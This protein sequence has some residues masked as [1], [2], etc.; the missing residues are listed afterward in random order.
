MAVEFWP[1]EKVTPAEY[2]P[3]RINDAKI[4]VLKE[5][6][7]K[8]GFIIP[9]LVNTK[10]NTIIAGHQRTKTANLLGLKTIPVNPVKDIRLGDEVRFNQIHNSIDLT[11]DNRPRL[12]SD[13]YDKEQFVYIPPEKFQ[14]KTARASSLKETCE[15]I[16]RYGNCLSCIVCKNEVVYGAEYVKAC[17]LLKLPVT[18]Y[19]ADDSKYQD[20]RYYLRQDYG[21]FCY[22]DIER[23][24]YVQGLAQMFR[25]PEGEVGTKIRNHSPL[26]SRWAIP[27]LKEA[28]KGTRVLDFGC[29]RGDYVPIMA[30][31]G[32]PSTGVEFYNH[33]GAAI[34]TAKGN[35][36]ID[37]LIK[38]LKE[39]GLFDVVICC[40][41]FNSVDSLEDED[42][43]MTCLNLFTKD[44]VFISGRIRDY[45][46]AAMNNAR[47]GTMRSA[48]N[49][50]DKDGFS[51]NYR[52]GHWFFQKF[53]N[54]Q[55]I[56]DL[57]HTHGFKINKLFY[58]KN[59]STWYCFLEKIDNLPEEQYHKAVNFEFGLVLPNKKRYNRQDE[60]W[61]VVKSIY[62][63][64]G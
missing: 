50:F 63:F 46:E 2:N 31:L 52:K 18:T 51:A 9:I 7:T 42:A 13:E 57:A 17:Q 60:V 27:Y 37:G 8:T 47:G 59:A 55:Q 3:R 36:M 23:H 53:H 26:H 33:N 30:K 62:N 19:I 35:R 21:E 49:F 40:G 4:E 64:E 1:I 29:G 22:E 48:M 10:N 38:E 14:V 20:L 45:V 34:N 15:L 16:V 25:N 41:V 56:E 24:T 5:S 54:R 44:K 6:I 32:F 28:G 39:N 11:L 43:V 12:L 58:T 61:D